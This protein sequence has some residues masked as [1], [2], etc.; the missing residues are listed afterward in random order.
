M[1]QMNSILSVKD[2]QHWYMYKYWLKSNYILYKLLLY[3][4][5]DREKNILSAKDLEVKMNDV[6]AI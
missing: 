5:Y 3:S 4:C 2:N 1:I 6:N